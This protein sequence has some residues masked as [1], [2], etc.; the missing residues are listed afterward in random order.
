MVIIGNRLNLRNV[1]LLTINPVQWARARSSIKGKE[2]GA[3]LSL[4]YFPQCSEDDADGD[5]D[6]DNDDDNLAESEPL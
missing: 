6:D 3:N 1:Q 5:K 2:R 4:Q